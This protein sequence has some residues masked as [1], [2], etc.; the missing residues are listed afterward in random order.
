M[1]AHTGGF[2]KWLDPLPEALAARDSS[3][4]GQGKGFLAKGQPL[5]EEAAFVLVELGGGV[6]CWLPLEMEEMSLCRRPSL[7]GRGHPWSQVSEIAPGIVSG[8]VL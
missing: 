1:A 3:P 5:E 7:G 8:A 2:R 4:Q 6:S